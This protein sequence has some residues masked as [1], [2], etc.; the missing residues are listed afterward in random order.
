MLGW[1]QRTEKLPLGGEPRGQGNGGGQEL[2]PI[3]WLWMVD[4]HPRRWLS[5]CDFSTAAPVEPT[6]LKRHDGTRHSEHLEVHADVQVSWRDQ[7]GGC[8]GL[9]STITTATATIPMAEG[10]V[11]VCLQGAVASSINH[12]DQ[13]ADDFGQERLVGQRT[14]LRKDNK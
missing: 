10:E 13:Q 12:F 5:I 9:A 14:Y 7:G 11:V 8:G 2:S 6:P 3:G 4:G 1:Q